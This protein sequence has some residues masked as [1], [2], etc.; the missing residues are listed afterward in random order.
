V[1]DDDD[2][3]MVEPPKS[4]HCAGALIFAEKHGRATQMMRICERLKMY[5][6]TKLEGHD[7]VF[8]SLPEMLH[9]QK[10]GG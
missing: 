2:D 5:D 4:K 7:T 10:D 6:A 9:A 8:A 3:D 1:A